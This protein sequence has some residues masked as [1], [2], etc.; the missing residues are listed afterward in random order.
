MRILYLGS[1]GQ[2]SNA[3]RRANALRRLGHQVEVL[4]PGT[5]LPRN[6]WLAALHF[7]TGYRFLLDR[8]FRHVREG[9]AGRRFELVWV[10]GGQIVGPRLVRWLR[11][12][13]APV[14]NYNN[15]DPFGTRDGRS[16]DSFKRAVP[17][18]DLLCVLRA[19]NV[20][21][22]QAL[23]ARR[24]LRVG[25]SYDP[26]AHR[27]RDLTPEEEARW[28]SEVVFVGTWMPE[29]G[30]F[31][32]RLMELGVPL[33]I[34]GNG[35][36]KASEWTELRRV[37]RGPGALG[38]DYVAAIQCSR[39]A[40]GLLSKGNRD[41]H[42]SRSVEIPFI[43]GLLCAERTSE[44]VEMFAEDREAVFWSTP[45][46]CAVNCRRLLED[47]SN[48]R[49]IAGAGRSRVFALKRSTDDVMQAILDAVAKREVRPEPEPLAWLAAG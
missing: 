26:V 23:G 36:N 32:R 21:E 46:E 9:I 37:H 43:G 47:E 13:V 24:V 44:H 25:A 31:F 35:W 42:T 15:D 12:E 28:S 20:A 5:Q 4:D 41:L 7:R 10:N 40:L 3:L 39:I 17:E 19:V 16:W 6:R 49:R 14:V 34:F 8:V 48:R 30:P 22:A 1:T 33:S 18:Y 38:P 45:E 27:R 11:E 2:N 29:R